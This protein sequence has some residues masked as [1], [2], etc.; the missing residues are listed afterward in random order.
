ML[1][2]IR[3]HILSVPNLPPHA[4]NLVNAP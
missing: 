3:F 2:I 4:G 1:V